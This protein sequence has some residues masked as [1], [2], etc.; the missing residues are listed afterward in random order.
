MGDVIM[1]VDDIKAII[2]DLRAAGVPYEPD[3]SEP[4]L[5]RQ[6]LALAAAAKYLA[7]QNAKWTPL[8]CRVEYA[9][10]WIRKKGKMSSDAKWFRDHKPRY[11]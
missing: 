11:R 9:M 3:H 7:L 5:V 2:A 8:R 6:Y 10:N 1:S 4:M